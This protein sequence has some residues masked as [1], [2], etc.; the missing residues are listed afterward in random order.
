MRERKR[1]S[2]EATPNIKERNDDMRLSRDAEFALR[3]FVKPPT[4]S[5]SLRKIQRQIQEDT[6]EWYSIH[7]LRRFLKE[8]LKYRYKKGS[9]RPIKYRANR[10]QSAKSLFWSELLLM[11]LRG[12][13]II[14]VDE[15]SFDRSIRSNYSWLPRGADSSII[16]DRVKGKAT[17]IL[18]TWN[19]GEWIGVVIIG[20]VDSIKFCI[21]MK[22]LELIVK[23]VYSNDDKML[24]VLIDNAKTHTSKLTRKIISKLAFKTRYLAPYWPEVAPVEQAF[25]LVK[26][27]LRAYNPDSEV[28]F[29]KQSGA[30]IILKFLAS[31]SP[32]SWLK[33]WLDTVRESKKTILHWAVTSIERSQKE[34]QI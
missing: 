14:N 11:I 7:T 19:T 18:G 9:S 22:L 21:F 12:E 2:S 1:N 23:A 25:G 28:N 31:I 8:K 17:L 32:S 5:V 34:E 33:A 30:K 29:D 3:N 6:K 20:T 13:T 4:T 26:S 16:N 27:K 24:T 15:S 10:A